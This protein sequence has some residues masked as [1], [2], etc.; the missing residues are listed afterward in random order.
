MIT[1]VRLSPADR[2]LILYIV[3]NLDSTPLYI[4]KMVRSLMHDL[5]IGTVNE[6]IKAVMGEIISWTALRELPDE[7]FSIDNEV[8]KQL[9]VLVESFDLSKRITPQG[10]IRVQVPPILMELFVELSEAL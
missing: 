8:L 7:E 10:E 4:A 5:R 1:Q 6:E 9:K 3:S 2:K